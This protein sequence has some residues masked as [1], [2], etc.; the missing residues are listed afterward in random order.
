VNIAD[1]F[2]MWDRPPGL[3]GTP[4]S[5]SLVEEEAGRGAGCRPGGLPHSTWTL[6]ALLALVIAVPA[7]A[8]VQ[9]GQLKLNLVGSLSGGYT[10]DYGNLTPSDH[11]IS[12]GGAGTLSGSFY[13][14]NFFSF[15]VQPFYNQS[16]EN[17]DYQSITASSGVTANASIFG[18][19]E[20]PGSIN[21]S[22]IFNSEGNFGVPGLA[23]FTSHGDSEVF[24]VGWSELV[25]H[26]P[27]LSF[28]Y[29]QGSNDYSLYGTDE[30]TASSFHSLSANS[31]YQFAGF[32]LAGNYHYTT[33]YL[34]VPEILSGAPDE[35]SDST[36]HSFGLSI[37]HQLPFN[38]N[39]SAGA[40]RSDINLD[41]SVGPYDATLDTINAGVG[42]NPIRHL[43]LGA[44]AQYVDNL[45]GAI[46]QSIVNAGGIA[47]PGPDTQKESTHSLD[48]TSYATFEV[49]AVHLAFNATEEHRDQAFDGT[50]L[51]S[52]SYT[53]TATYSNTVWNGYLNAVAG[54]TRTSISPS[55]QSRLGALGSLNY[56]REFGRW[57]VSALGNYSANQQTLL[58]S[59]TTSSYGFAGSVGRKI[60]RRAHWNATASG[61]HSGLTAEKGSS[62]SSQSYS[63]AFSTRVFSVSATYS[64]SDGNA[65][66]T[67]TGLT[68]TSVP[69]PVVTPSAV[70]LYGGRAYTF[71]FGSSPFRGLTISA[72]YSHAA[73]STSGDITGNFANETEQFNTRI[74]YL[75]RKI[76][77]Q[78][79]YSR[80]TQSF[81]ASGTPPA[82]VA[83]FYF[84]LTRWF[85]FF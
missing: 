6:G 47:S 46:Y 7:R 53:G 41:S 37:S 59:Y 22:R 78:A 33:T 67:G 9:L 74:Q 44:N 27:T 43:S 19:S 45:T 66:L 84:G 15:N 52:E 14:P 25:P 13:N 72:S 26:L 8:Q 56:S 17:S 70:V 76:Y 5:R 36:S 81:S 49:P 4:S 69:L 68:A 24:G 39:I 34:L 29:Q 28:G 82:M 80:L 35:S 62:S 64:R 63:T 40:S 65:L 77:F 73:S 18:G 55:D 38:G 10:G 48:V 51:Q 20:F 58:I 61:A 3:R 50:H 16:R 30:N 71:G 31:T 23:N 57:T 32:K 83:S 2:M 1:R 75:V 54:I 79:G 12:G 60:G 42:F 85:T 11:G 21:Y